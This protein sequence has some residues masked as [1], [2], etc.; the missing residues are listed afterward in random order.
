[1]RFAAP[2]RTAYDEPPLHDL[3]AIE[4]QP[5]TETH[6]GRHV[7]ETGNGSDTTPLNK[8]RKRSKNQPSTCSSQVEG[9]KPTLGAGNRR[10]ERAPQNKSPSLGDGRSGVLA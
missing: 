8:E 10:G 9:H 1:L 7:T 3:K 2:A 4:H 5:V 6:P